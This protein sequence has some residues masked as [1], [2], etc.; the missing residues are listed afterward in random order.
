M[1]KDN[2]VLPA[3]RGP[4]AM[5]DSVRCAVSRTASGFLA[6]HDRWVVEAK[7][8]TGSRTV[9]EHRVICQAF[10]FAVQEGLHVKNLACF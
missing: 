6:A 2:S 9:Y 8:D 4:R 10:H 7:M 5:E 3:I 1:K